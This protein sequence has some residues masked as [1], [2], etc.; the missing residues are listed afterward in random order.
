MADGTAILLQR[1]SDFEIGYAVLALRLL[2][3]HP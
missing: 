1:I 2:E 3:K